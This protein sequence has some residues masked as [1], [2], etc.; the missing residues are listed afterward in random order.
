MANHEVL[1]S[2]QDNTSSETSS[3]WDFVCNNQSES[4]SDSEHLI[5]NTVEI[6]NIEDLKQM[7]PIKQLSYLSSAIEDAEADA[8]YANSEAYKTFE[9]IEN[10]NSFSP[11]IRIVASV[12]R[13]LNPN[14]ERYDYESDIYSPSDERVGYS[15]I[16]RPEMIPDGVL[17]PEEES[18]SEDE[19][20][21]KLSQ[22]RDDLDNGW[23]TVSDLEREDWM[24]SNDSLINEFE[25]ALTK[26]VFMK[27]QEKL[28]SEF[29]TLSK[30]RQLVKIASN[31]AAEVEFSQ[32]YDEEEDWFSSGITIGAIA[33]KD[34]RM[35]KLDDE[36]ATYLSAVHQN[37]EVKNVVEEKLGISLADISIES[38]VGLLR[39]MTEASNERFDRLCDSLHSVNKTTRL[40]LAEN[41][42]AAD[43]G[44]DFGDALLDIAG[45]EKLSN[46]EKERLLDTVG[47]CRESISRVTRMYTDFDDGKFA[48]EYARAS[49]ERLTDALAVFQQIAKNGTAEADLDW[50]GKPRFDFDTA[51][52]ALEF[53]SK[54]LEIIS[55]T[56][57]DVAARKNGAFAEVV[58]TPDESDQRLNRTF[59][60]FYS[61]RHGYV[62]LYTRPE[63]THSFD[64]MTEYGKVRSR[65]NTDSVNAGAE[66]SISLI[67]N[68]V[69]P[70]SLPSPFR[71]DRRAVR[72]PRFYD[73]VTM[74]KV[75]AIRLDREG[76]APGMAAD[77]ALR[78]P[79]NPVGMVS[80][81]LAAI[82][83]R[84]DTPSGKIARLL[85]VGGKL[86]EEMS[87]V[88]SSLN[89]NTKWFDQDAYG[90]ADGFSELV[91]YLDKMATKWCLESSPDDT[92]ESFSRLMKRNRGRKVRRV[93]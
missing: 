55:G 18:M 85:S 62:L 36:T 90:T 56:L 58:L 33:D 93:A 88:T 13:S 80:V 9:A 15:T 44:E 26:K 38:Q 34:G 27:N 79:I 72:N 35:I 66:A 87:G 78:D 10:S 89:H 76:R 7:S 20:R 25:L 1:T 31:A 28:H 24:L 69:D 30:N 49:N 86:R 19:I 47:A 39:F 50:A 17:T 84:V 46:A 59:Y 22:I 23:S 16:L 54:S 3:P 53:E 37:Q 42:L 14:G 41:F 12:G 29:P 91:G 11:L 65:Y 74:D 92:A 60:N 4:Y 83:D 21:L 73:P 71:P 40:K 64:P 6:Q 70:F 43:F 48:K 63:G 61:P 67:T 52:E 75:S 2:N 77:D 81:D 8:F 57:G 68:P 5:R 51:M 45:S 32:K 82:G